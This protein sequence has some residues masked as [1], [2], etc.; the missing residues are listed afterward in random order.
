M[1]TKHL[2]TEVWEWIFHKGCEGDLSVWPLIEPDH[3]ELNVKKHYKS[4]AA[5]SRMIC[6]Y[7]KEIIDR[8]DRFWLTQVGLNYRY[9]KSVGK[10][11]KKFHKVRILLLNF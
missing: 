1:T 2:P 7:W 10:Q 11:M 5:D 3:V 9:W 4:F 6:K 8:S